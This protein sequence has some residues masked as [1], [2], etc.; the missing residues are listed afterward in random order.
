MKKI[1]LT[2]G[3]TA[4]HVIPHF[5]LL[6][7]LEKE[8]INITYIGS[9]NGIEKELVTDKNILYLSISTGKLRRYFDVKNFTD[10]FR[11]LAGFFQSI[12]HLRKVRPDIIFSKGGFVSVPVVLA[13]RLLGI[14][15]VCHESDMTPGL[16]TKISAP[17]ATKILTTFEETLTYLPEGKAI[18]TGSPIRENLS[19]GSKEKA[20]RFT[21]LT[22]NKPI[23]LVMG[24]SL[25]SVKINQSLRS[26]LPT[27]LK[28]YQ[29]IHLC[30]KGNTD[31]GLNHLEGYRQY[32]YVS[33]EL[34]DIFAITDGII[35][36]A[37]SNAIN[38]FVYLCIPSLLIPL[39]KSASRG[40]QI[41]NA[42]SFAKKGY[43]LLLE[44]ED[45]NEATLLEHIKTLFAQSTEMTKTLKSASEGSGTQ[46][47]YNLLVK[48]S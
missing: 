44:E 26:I 31:P 36:R 11:I 39:S 4:G 24:G 13:G 32:E 27:L 38:E 29:V 9:K 23:I 25:G 40:D 35:S 46:N 14:P 5:A 15:V 45:L 34:M 16:A 47:V 17:F 30:G 2:G 1:V 19:D 7:Y 48:I 18:H 43:S 6:P 12:G 8:H 22:P 21:G 42:R 41:L 37:G 33:D 3:G 20:Y 28:S 10:P